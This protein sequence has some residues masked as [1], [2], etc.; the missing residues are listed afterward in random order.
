MKI[1]A[2]IDHSRIS[3]EKAQELMKML[4]C[5]AAAKNETL[6]PRPT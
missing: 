1:F 6:V 3:H 5:C 4:Q 2:S